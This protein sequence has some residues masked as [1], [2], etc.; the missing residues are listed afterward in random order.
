M[1]IALP[2]IRRRFIANI[3]LRWILTVPFVFLT[4]GAT[5]WVGYLSYQSGRKALEDLGHQLALEVNNQVTQELKTNLKIPV[6]I[7]RLNVDAVHQGQVDPENIPALEA[8]LF[9][10]LQQFDQVS[11]I[12]FLNPQGKFRVVERLPDLYMGIADPPRPDQLLIYRL[13]SQ[14]NRGQWVYTEQGLDVRRDRPWY[15]RAVTTGK[16]GWSPVSQYGTLK[17]LTLDASQPV[18]DRTTKNLLG[19]FAV[20]IRLD[21]LSQFLQRLNI[22]RL[23]QVII[24]DQSGA[25]IATSVPEQLYK[26]EADAGSGGPFRQLNLDESQNHLTRSLGQYLRH[27]PALLSSL[28]QTQS[29]AFQ[30]NDEPHY[31]QITPFQDPY[32]LN[33]RILTVIPKSHFLG[34]IQDNGRTTALLCLLT[35]GGAIALGLCVAHYLTAHFAQLNQA[36]RELAADHLAQQLPT[37][38]PIYELNSLAQTFNQMADQ[39]QQSFVGIKT[40]LEESEEK[41]ATIFRTSP[42][43]LAIAT[44]AEEYILEVNDSLVECFGYSRAE[45]IG[46]TLLELNLWSSQDEHDHYRA[47]LQQQEKVSNLEIQL[48]TKSGEI[49]TVLL[50][51]EIQTLEGQDRL[52]AMYRD[53]SDRK[54]AE[55]ALQQSEARHRSIIEDQTELISRSTPDTTIL[56][57]NDAYCRYFN[58]ERKDVIHKKFV[59]FVY[60]ADRDRVTQLMRSLSIKNPTITMENR[61]I[62]NGVIRWTQWSNRLLFDEQNNVT[63][64]QSVG[65]DITELKQI[66]AALRQS[67]VRFRQLAESVREGFFVYE[68]E[69]AHYSY[70]NP[71]YATILGISSQA[72]YTEMSHWLNHIHPD[73]RDRIEAALQREHQGEHF[74]E[75][76]RWLRQGE[77]RWLRSQAFPIRNERGTIVR[78]VGTVEDITDR[79]QLEQSLRSQAEEERLLANIT[80]HIRQSLNLEQILATT[81]IEVQQT[82][83][84]D[85]ALIFQLNSDGSG[86]V[87]QAAV[88]PGYSLTDPMSGADDHFSEELY[89]YYQQGIPRIEYHRAT[90][91]P[92]ASVQ[93]K[94][95]APIVQVRG[96]S[97]TKVWGLLVVHACSYDRQWQ[98]SEVDFL[99]QICNQLAIA[100]DQAN[101]YHQLQVELA[102]RKQAEKA[103]QERE[104]ML[105]A[106]GD[107]LPK[108]FIY[109]RVYEPGRGFYYSYVSAGI[110]RLLG[111]KPEAVLKNPKTTR[112]V[113]FDEDLTIADR[114]VQESL[115]NLSPIELQMRNRTAQGDIQWSSIRSI[116][117]RLDDGR[118]VWDGVE[119]DITDLKRTETALR[120][121]EEQF[122]RAFDDAPIGISLVLPTGQFV[123]VNVC[124]CDLLRYTEAELLNLTVQRVTD[125][126]DLKAYLEGFRQMVAGERRSFQM[127]KQYVTKQGAI[128][129]VLINAAPV[130]DQ[131]GQMLY[132]VEHIQ[133]IRNRRKV[134]RM[135]NEFISVVSHELRTPLTSIQGALGILGSRV[136]DDRPEK[137]QHMLKIALDNSDRL[138]RLVNDILSLER[139]ES[140]KVP[141]VMER[142]QV[143]D[144]IQQAIDSV[145]TLAEQSGIRL[146]VTP[147]SALLWVA[148]DAIVQALINLLSNAIKFSA[149]GDTVWLKAEMRNEKWDLRKQ[150]HFSSL[151]MPCLLFS[152]TDQGRGIPEDKLEIIFEQF[153][154]VDVSDSRKKG[155]TGLGLA[156]CRN[157]VQQ[158]GG[159]IWAESRV[160][161]GSTFYFALPLVISTR[162]Q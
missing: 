141:L 126:R 10:R 115:K 135:K 128:V 91:M 41:F 149:P 116:P 108:G 14:G 103:L 63:E 98:E 88:A 29:L 56:F 30:Y 71:A 127:E 42:D 143:A 92:A 158:H 19:V 134:E 70:V 130:R 27:H 150:R 125:P 50:S 85:R 112:M 38:H 121:S 25:L 18:Y 83:K 22:S 55:R 31:V 23:G 152:V 87:I 139:L 15:H 21:S 105:R 124:Y 107:N 60:E 12:L 57:V 4:A 79:K 84:V 24:T 68:T 1:P 6:L 3:P 156:I 97:S 34:A 67:E 131:A 81:V 47:L 62:V 144:L 7:N 80:Q 8:S 26:I 99:E 138:V 43:P 48:H 77:L 44:L 61:V 11:A 114:T 162:T 65:R 58:V 117:R 142:C 140:G 122:R 35:L 90:V 120:A 89:R 159:Q 113:G 53:I 146:S 74:N 37:D 123:K 76:Y 59:P 154:Q 72:V 5:A 20:H 153:Q 94:V 155:G 136:F 93:S 78:V 2:Q 13:D 161:E 102:E 111:I 46:Y 96:E 69:S 109:Q 28:D 157:I 145:Q 52:I 64:I 17:A 95:I 49:K 32:G 66:E 16:P 101:L 132:V 100:I 118:T 133:D 151:P 73:D 40:A 33:W 129:P 39:L 54:A 9:N 36:S 160:G 104:A 148:Q 86:Q 45:M 51:V 119:V 137:A 106:I 75:E 147:C 82:L 110:E